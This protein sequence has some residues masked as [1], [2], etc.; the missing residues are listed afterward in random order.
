[1]SPVVSAEVWVLLQQCSGCFI[2]PDGKLGGAEQKEFTV[3]QKSHE[4]FSHLERK[5]DFRTVFAGFFWLVFFFRFP[6]KPLES[7]ECVFV[8][9]AA[10]RGLKTVLAASCC[11]QS[12]LAPVSSP[13]RSLTLCTWEEEGPH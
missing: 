6:L 1:M 2:S 9:A 3:L 11:W 8:K 5:H 7:L 10:C 4:L 12:L 13:A